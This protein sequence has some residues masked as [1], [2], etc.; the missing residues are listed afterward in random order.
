MFPFSEIRPVQKDFMDDIKHCLESS[1]HLIAN[2]PTGLGKTAATIATALEFALEHG[3]TVFFLTPKHSQHQIA[4]DTLRMIKKKFP[5]RSFVSTDII[6]KK[7]LCSVTGIQDLK[8][9]EFHNYCRTVVKEERCNYYN[10]TRTK[11]HSLTVQAEKRLRQMLVLQPLHAEETLSREFCPYEILT[12]MA[13]KSNI[14]IGDY[15]H[16]FSPY[17]NAM[18]IRM[19]KEL[20]D[21]ILIIDEGHNLP[22]RVR[23]IMTRK[24]TSLS[25][26]NAMKEA[27]AFGY[28]D[29]K[30]KI[31]G[32][33]EVLESIR[34]EKLKN[35]S[36]D[37]VEKDLFI[38]MAEKKA[39]NMDDFI[40]M[41]DQGAEEVIKDK[42]RSFM[43]TLSE[44]LF[45][46]YQS[47]EKGYARI[48]SKKKTMSGKGFVSLSLSCL[49]PSL[50]TNDIISGS[51][52]T[53]I[54]SGTLSPTEMYRDVLGFGEGRAEMR[55][56]KS[57]FLRKN[58]LNIIVKG[59]TTKYS[60]RTDENYKKIAGHIIESCHAIPNN[61]AI[62]FPSYFMRD[63]VLDIAKD[64]LKKE[65]ILEEQ[66]AD[67]S[68]KRMIYDRFVAAHEKGA[69]LFG[70]QAGS[71]AEGVDLPGKFLNGVIVVGVP[72]ERP[73]LETK[74]LIDYYDYKF[75]RG[76]DYG[77]I[78]PAMVRSI[79]AAGRCIRSESDR[80]VCL[81]LDERFAWINYRKVFPTDLDIRV[82]DDPVP[83]VR[84]FFVVHL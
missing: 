69:V 72:L 75:S 42:R 14:I 35:T 53:I 23:S 51:H 26:E 71:F 66:N 41:L 65:I 52:S 73:D 28:D 25:L 81:F 21:M 27:K 17:R 18:L 67:K 24:I 15:Y 3:K 9:N 12:D 4:I 78:Y 63:L 45:N 20:S 48:I 82:T 50:Y 70:V 10:N 5:D 74:A 76:W 84:E 64:K 62:F 46:W 30:Q 39:G 61:V 7:W 77:Y 32:I 6:G 57:P 33:M 1:R 36:E 37:F 54:M 79:Q 56:Y 16:I 58:R 80:G 44:F 19:K 55:G 47:E 60:M 31:I 29:A 13:K 83:L 11:S 43:D 49:D 2:A 68:E 38:Q 34:K 59:V 8:S 40:E 22:D